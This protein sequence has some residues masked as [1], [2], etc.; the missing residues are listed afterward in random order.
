MFCNFHVF[1]KRNEGHSAALKVVGVPRS[2]GVDAY[3]IFKREKYCLRYLAPMVVTEICFPHFG[4]L[5]SDYY[6]DNIVQEITA[7]QKQVRRFSTCLPYVLVDV[8]RKLLIHFLRYNSAD[9]W[10]KKEKYQPTWNTML[11]ESLSART[12]GHFS[13]KRSEIS[14]PS[15]HIDKGFQSK[16]YYLMMHN[17]FTIIRNIL[18]TV[19]IEFLICVQPTTK[20]SGSNAV[21]VMSLSTIW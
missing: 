3:H 18:F 11:I 20:S 21:H 16:Y 19:F 12:F 7:Q 17:Y 4:G 15:F 5:I 2:S 10:D 1:T 13:P 14:W 9:L 8:G 6:S